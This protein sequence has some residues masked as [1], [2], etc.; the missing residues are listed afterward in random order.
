VRF[1]SF[2]TTE[3]LFQR[4]L[5]AYTITHA[6]EDKN[7]LRFHVDYFRPEG[8][9]A[10]K[11]GEA[12]AKRAIID[13]VL[14]KHDAATHARRFNALFATASINDAI[15]YYQLFQDLQSERQSADASFVP[16]KVACVFSPPAQLAQP[17]DEKKDISQLADDLEQEKQD[18]QV[19]PEK[20]KAAL[21]AIIADYNARY[22]TNHSVNEFDLYYQDVQ[23]RIKDQQFPN[24]DLPKMGAEKIDITLVVDMLLTGFDSKYLNTLYVDKNLKHHGLIQAFSRTNRVLNATKPHGQILDFR[25][26]QKQVDEAITL[27]S[28]VKNDKTAREIWLVDPAPKV[29][30]KLKEALTK[31]GDFLA[32]QDLPAKPESVPALK[33]DEA[34][35]AFIERFREVQRLK[36]QLDQYTDLKPDMKAQVEAL[37]PRDDLNAYRGAYLATAQDLKERQGKTGDKAPS[38]VVE[39]LDFEFV[40]FASAVIDYD[41]IMKLLANFSSKTPGKQ[42]MNREQLIGLIAADAKFIDERELITDYVRS[43]QAGQGQSEKEI[44]EGY[45]R[46]KS[47]RLGAELAAIAAQHGLAAEPLRAFTDTILQRMVFDGEQLTELMA[48][49]GLGWRERRVK[50]LALMDALVPVLK[51]R[52]AGREISGLS[53]YES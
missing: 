26:Q 40:L 42:S 7:V 44:R 15:E 23:K 20:K 51:K 3:D 37:L 14:D 5:H 36:T 32:S 48:P 12:L 22:G 13:A 24:A 35:A 47:E 43:L 39:Q 53:A 4:E 31:L 33:G 11:P 45:Q 25:A 9:D 29:V 27:F 1:R 30:D 18:N 19:E 34:R 6:I 28:G 52:A 8:K 17:P 50:E 16:L 46:F 41:Y 2:R 10:P 38:P 21:K 49:L